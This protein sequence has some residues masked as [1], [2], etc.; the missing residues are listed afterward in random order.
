[1][2]IVNPKSIDVAM[3]AVATYNSDPFMPSLEPS[4]RQDLQQTIDNAPNGEIRAYDVYDDEYSELL[5]LLWIDDS[6][7]AVDELP[8]EIYTVCHNLLTFATYSH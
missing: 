6:F 7:A 5:S 8:D 2:R 3:I 1:M 4:V